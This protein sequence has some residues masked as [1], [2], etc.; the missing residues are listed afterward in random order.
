VGK[1]TG[2]KEY[3][4]E[5]PVR[6]PVNERVNDYFEVYQPFPEEKV[7]VQAA[8][9]MDCG[10]AFCHSGCP[11]GNLIPEWNEF[12]ARDDWASRRTRDHRTRRGQRGH[13]GGY[14]R[15]GPGMPTRVDVVE[16]L[17]S[18][19]LLPAIVFIFRRVGCDAPRAAV[20]NVCDEIRFRSARCPHDRRRYSLRCARFAGFGTNPVRSDDPGL[21]DDFVA[22]RLKRH[23]V[24]V[25]STAG[26]VHVCH[27]GKIDDFGNVIQSTGRYSPSGYLASGGEPSLLRFASP[28]QP[29]AARGTE[30]D[31]DAEHH[32][33]N[34]A[35]E[36][37]QCDGPHQDAP[38]QAGDQGGERGLHRIDEPEPAP[39]ELASQQVAAE[40]GDESDDEREHG[41]L[42]VEDVEVT[43]RYG[44]SD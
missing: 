42:R 27:G 19:G 37:E 14:S 44:T 11:L 24:T 25:L 35:Q 6:R 38:N 4:R 15:R 13:Q 3:T 12:V 29:G 2:F 33:G 34:D 31:A 9:C 10:V 20:A 21:R 41:A 28:D 18:E 8:R 22:E 36:R 43:L 7:R 30:T 26:A 39:D 40:P 1:V 23:T 16:R 17:D 32:D 5:T